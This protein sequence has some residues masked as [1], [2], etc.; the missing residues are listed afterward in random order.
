MILR[1]NFILYCPLFNNLRKNVLKK[2]Y[3]YKPSVLKLIELL[4]T[5]N[6]SDLLKVGKFLSAAVSLRKSKMDI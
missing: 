3:Y 2:Y 5:S 4:S 6:V 1:M